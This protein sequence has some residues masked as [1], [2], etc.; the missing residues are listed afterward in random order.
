MMLGVDGFTN[1]AS[2]TPLSADTWRHPCLIPLLKRRRWS[3]VVVAG[4]VHFILPQVALT[5][6]SFLERGV[7]ENHIGYI[8]YDEWLV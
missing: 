3:S 5:T 2:I 8:V 6:C 7:L 4:S 1:L